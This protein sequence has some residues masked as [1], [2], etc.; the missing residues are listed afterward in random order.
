[1]YVK[2]Y[3]KIYVDIYVNIYFN[4]NVNI[5]VNNSLIIVDSSYLMKRYFN[6]MPIK[7]KFIT[8]DLG[9]INE[10]KTSGTAINFNRF[11]NILPNGA[12]QFVVN[13]PQP[14]AAARTPKMS[15]STSPIIIFQ[16]N[17]SFMFTLLCY[18]RIHVGLFT[19]FD[20]IVFHKI[21]IT[22]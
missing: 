21:S 9:K 14:F 19:F 12:I 17:S 6:S 4:I 16:C 3:V 11:I 2:I 13:P 8:D 15:P 1:M 22:G 7:N 18:L 10:D 20:F 5:Y